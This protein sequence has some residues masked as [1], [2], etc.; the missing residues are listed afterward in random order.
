MMLAERNTQLWI[1]YTRGVSV[2]S[3]LVPS[4]RNENGPSLI[5]VENTPISSHSSVRP[6]SCENSEAGDAQMAKLEI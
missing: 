2:L 4:C 1:N 3:D 5:S 6:E